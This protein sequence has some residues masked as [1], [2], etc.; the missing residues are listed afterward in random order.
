MSNNSVLR[1]LRCEVSGN[2]V[3]REMHYA[4][5]HLDYVNDKCLGGGNSLCEF[6]K[7]LSIH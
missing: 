2:F 3:V 7:V 6:E 1:L 4:F 5:A